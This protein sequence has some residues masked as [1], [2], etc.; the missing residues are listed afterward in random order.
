MRRETA[1]IAGES[2]ASEPAA[3]S[4]LLL[5]L[6]RG[7]APIQVNQFWF[8]LAFVGLHQ[9]Q[10]ARWCFGLRPLWCIAISVGREPDGVEK[11]TARCRRDL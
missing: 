10:P 4:V 2:C 5:K 11:S 1:V 6:P 9:R 8:A 3:R 7:F